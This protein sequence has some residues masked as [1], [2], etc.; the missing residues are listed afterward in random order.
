MNI[1]LNKTDS[2]NAVIT[3]EVEKADYVTEVENSL[4]D[5][6]K[7][8]VLP[9]FRKGMAPPSFLR[10][11]YGK[12]VLVEEINKLVSKKLSEYIQENKTEIL[13]E[14][15]PAEEQ[16][17]IDFDKQEDFVFSFDVG[18]SP[19][20]DIK[21]TKDDQVPYYLIQVSD[22]MID[23]Q[24]EHLKNKYG[25]QEQG[26]TVEDKDLVK[27]HLIELDENGASKINGINLE[28][29]V[30]MPMYI[31][32]EGEKEKM[33][34]SK[35]HS[36][37]VFNPYSAYDGSEVE[38]ASFLSV[39]KEEVKNH[40]GNFSY[41]IVEINRFKEAELNQELFDKVYGEGNIESEE[42]FREKV[43]EDLSQ[44][45]TPESDYKFFIDAKKMLEE[46]A[47]DLQLPDAFLK[48]WLLA[49]D[50]KRTPESVEE[51]Y[52]K[53]VNDLKFHLIKE[54]L[55]E[56]NE[57]TLDDNDLQEYAKQATRAQFAQYGMYT[58][59]DDLLEKY[60]QEMLKK[61]ESYRALGEKIFEDKLIKILKEQVTLETKEISID[62]FQQ[63][64]TDNKN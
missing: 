38:L 62:E 51:E 4:K 13:G 32:N 61:Q 27:G 52:P 34:N 35:L 43:K 58:V 1:T 12:S 48:R 6:R 29:A 50:T 60:S 7:N 36:T 53:I 14:P 26:E 56:E 21:L 44:Q 46:K 54:H 28:S 9:G 23:K 33:I 25:N 17:Q 30:I 42:K 15:L 8:A 64:F 22:E 37:I 41:E 59:P 3:I 16:K 40:T 11:K 19:K 31:K 49:S 47:S 20:I 63:L 55:I 39:K 45:L 2:V 24:I 5:L 18:L 10:Q 57:I